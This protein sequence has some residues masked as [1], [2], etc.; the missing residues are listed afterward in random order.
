MNSELGY[1]LREICKDIPKHQIKED[2]FSNVETKLKE[3][4]AFK[5]KIE[6]NILRMVTIKDK[7]EE[8]AGI[9]QRVDVIV[10]IA[11]E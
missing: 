9:A 6:L 11:P 10:Q 2:M 4:A 8:M 5:K 3:L 7:I 1:E